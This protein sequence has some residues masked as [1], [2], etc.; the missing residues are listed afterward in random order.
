LWNVVYSLEKQS[1]HP[2]SEALTEFAKSQGGVVSTIGSFESIT[3]QGIKGC[4]ENAQVLIG[5]QSMIKGHEVLINEKAHKEVNK[6][7]QLGH[8]PV[9]VAICGKLVALI[10]ILDPVKPESEAAIRTLESMGIEVWMATGDSKGSAMRV[11]REVGIVRTMADVLP[12]Q[13]LEKVMELQ[14]KGHKVAMVGDGINDS[15][16]L[17]QADVG[18]AMGTGTDIAMESAGVTLVKGEILSLVHTL[19]ISRATMRTVR[20]NLFFSFLYNGLGIPLAAGLF[21]P[22]W[23]VLL[24]PIVASVAMA[25]SSL[26]VITNSLRL[27]KVPIGVK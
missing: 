12:S 21:Y 3:G 10:G 8:T 26:S 9:F 18:F 11:A 27:K 25:L 4:V 7:S 19:Q 24:S 2:L 22:L 16:A 5:N 14:E 20:Q 6:W 17:A 13:K 1:E 23:G 15:P